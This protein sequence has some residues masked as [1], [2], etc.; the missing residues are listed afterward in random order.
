MD[1]T[2]DMLGYPL[3]DHVG[4][5]MDP[6]YE[7]LRAAGTLARATL[8]YGD[9][10][11]LATSY[12]HVRTVLGDPRFSRAE[13]WHHD[14]PRIG[15]ERSGLGI[16]AMDPPDHTKLRRMVSGAFSARRIEPLRARAAEL[17]DDLLTNCGDT[18]DVV[19]ELAMPLSIT[20]I[21]ELIGVPVDDRGFVFEWAEAFLTTTALDK[22]EIVSRV[23]RMYNYLKDLVD[24]RIAEPGTDLIST[25]TQAWSADPES[26]ITH[27][28]LVWLGAGL[29]VAGY[30]TTASQ[31]AN[32]VYV[33]LTT[34]GK[35][36]ELVRQPELV[37]S[38]VEELLRFVPLQTSGAFPRFATEDVELG[39]VTVHKGDAVLPDIVAA[40]RDGRVFGCPADVELAR[41]RN[42]HLAFGFGIHHCLGAPLARVE[43][44]VALAALTRFPR[45]ELAI[46][47]EQVQW[48]PGMLV[49]GPVELPV[50]R[51]G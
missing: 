47:F 9:P 19:N 31:L 46:D 3:D 36:D 38:A 10:T 22:D 1:A 30:E 4:L 2:E 16:L 25:V 50:R 11:W 42:Q 49:R 44:Q 32:T 6:A 41:P 33:L 14:E 20:M 51:L 39:G 7:Q 43:L 18:F 8:A 23:G 13:S 21:C 15:P 34:P 29:L 17:V 48:K 35:W 40:N 37:D 45:L 5:G 24:Q 27:E 26:A 12:D 28:D